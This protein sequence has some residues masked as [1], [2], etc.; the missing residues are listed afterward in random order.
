MQLQ[1]AVSDILRSLQLP[2]LVAYQVERPP[3]SSES[4]LL[5]SGLPPG[6]HVCI[7]ATRAQDGGGRKKAATVM[8]MTR[9]NSQELLDHEEQEISTLDVGPMGSLY[10]V[11]KLRSIRNN[12]GGCSHAP[13]DNM[14]EDDFISRGD[15]NLEEAEELFTAFTCSL[16]HYLWGG[17][18]LVHDDLASVRRSSSLLSVAILTVAALHIINKTRTFDICYE[19]FVKLVSNSMLDRWHDLDEVRALCIGA[20]WLTDVSC[21]PNLL[22][23]PYQNI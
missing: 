7:N 20:F 14:L 22:Y 13:K 12:P 23:L 19:E 8:A 3:S 21:E 11:T 18:A 1:A 2:A 5:P 4:I 6:A 9:E 10:E 15:I 16:N 17:V